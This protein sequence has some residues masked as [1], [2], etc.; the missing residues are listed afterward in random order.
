MALIG[1]CEKNGLLAVPQAEGSLE[2]GIRATRLIVDQIMPVS[3]RIRVSVVVPCRNEIRF[4]RG[5]L[6]SI[7]SQDYRRDGCGNRDC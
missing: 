6:D 4:I 2:M 3:E 1:I 7:S 5:F